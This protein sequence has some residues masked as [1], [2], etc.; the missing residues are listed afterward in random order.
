MRG[1]PEFKQYH[2]SPC[3]LRRCGAGPLR[4]HQ[5]RAAAAVDGQGS[6]AGSQ[7]GLALQAARLSGPVITRIPLVAWIQRVRWHGIE[8]LVLRGVCS[9]VHCTQHV[10]C[11]GS[12]S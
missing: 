1:E 6:A 10:A 8:R 12:L 7:R 11:I 3:R 2:I 5:G 4:G 9:T